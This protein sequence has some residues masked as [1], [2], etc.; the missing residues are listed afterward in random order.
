M[1]LALVL[2]A[3]L[4]TAPAAG[5]S[6]YVIRGRG[7]GHGIGMSQWG[8]YGFAK[9]GR[10]FAWILRHYYRGTN[11]GTAADRTIRVL[12]QSGEPSISFAGATRVGSVKLKAAKTY[13]ARLRRDGRI[14]VGGHLLPAPVNGSGAGGAIRLGGRSLNGVLD[15]AYR[16]AIELSAGPVGGLTAVNAVDVE[17]Y[18]K[19]VVPAEVPA[20]WP[21]E[22]LKAQAVAARTYALATQ[23]LLFPDT[24]SQVYEG[25][26]AEAA[27]S[28][29]AVDAT[30]RRV[31]RYHGRIAITYFFSASGGHT[32]DVENVFYGSPR[33]PYLRGVKDPFDGSAPRHQWRITLSTA[34]VQAR[35]RGLVKGSFRGIRVLARGVSPRVVWAEVVGSA[36]VTRL[37]GA[38]LAARVG[39]YD[40][41][42]YFPALGG[43]RRTRAPAAPAPPAAAGRPAAGSAPSNP[44][45]FRWPAAAWDSRG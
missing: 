7:Y 11:L 12:L 4:L 33:R 6:Q 24:R 16:G 44:P 15:G 28:D 27:R 20:T 22:A 14:A 42:A 39:L 19:G 30:A 25:L 17:G 32:E 38:A 2:P 5:A 41:W 45:G 10:A 43:A 23:G 21:G 1:M 9:H 29:A 18:V 3:L 35:L 26:D 13:T 34:Q 37:R 31:V 8:A 36:G 40:T